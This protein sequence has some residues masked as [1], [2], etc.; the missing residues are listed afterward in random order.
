VDLLTGGAG[1]DLMAGGPGDDTYAVNDS[2]D[3]VTEIG[4][5]GKDT[6]FTNVNYALP[7]AARVEFLTA[8]SSAGL[9]L[10]GNKF[11]NVITGGD[12]A[13]TLR[14]GAG[15]DVLK[16]GKGSDLFNFTEL[17]D[18]LVGLTARDTIFDFSLA[19]GDRIGLAG[20]DANTVLA[21]DQAFVFV[22]SAAFSNVAGQLRATIA[23]GKTTVSG[24]V[25]GDG[26]ADF[27][28]NLNGSITL[29]SGN[30][31]L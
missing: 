9:V 15:A 20:I 1:V 12:G 25:N 6:I 5:E 3:H 7:A 17:K 23:S 8:G 19:E 24:D 21:G 2:S 28:I 26:V 10:T 11:N 4:T 13:D 18:S 31:I 14:G 30:F 16:G 29:A 22:G 27:A